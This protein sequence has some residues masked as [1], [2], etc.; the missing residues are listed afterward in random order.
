MFAVVATDGP[1]ELDLKLDES[2]AG[3][4]MQLVQ[5]GQTLPVRFAI[6]S[7]PTRTYQAVV[8]EIGGVARRRADASNVVDVVARVQR[9]EEQS[10]GNV[11][12]TAEGFRGDVD[13]TA[14]LVCAPRRLIDS[15]SDELVAWVH[16][17]ILFRF[18]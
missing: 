8:T 12:L 18:R 1:W 17:N 7:Q 4:V 15:L 2:K 11:P 16:R 3:E 5:S 9:S 6:A 10:D 13:V 14:K